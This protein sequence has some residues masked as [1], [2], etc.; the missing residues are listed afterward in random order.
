MDP[1]KYSYGVLLVSEDK[2]VYDIINF[3]ENLGWEENENE[4]AARLSFTAKNDNTSKGWLSSLAKP[5]CYVYL[6]ARYANGAASERMRGRIV[7]WNPSAKSREEILKI[8]AY[9]TLY[10]LQ[11]SKD[12]VYFSSGA[13]TRKIIT[14]ILSKWNIGL[15]AYTGPNVKHGTIKEEKKKLG[16]MLT[17]ILKEAKKKGGPEAIIRAVKGKVQVVK[18]CTNTKMY[19]FYE[20]ENLT[21]VSHKISTAGMITRVKVLGEENDDGKRPVEA[22]VNGKT[23]YGIRQDILIRGT[24]E[25]IQEAKKTARETLKEDGVPTE[26][27]KVVTADIP[28]LRKGD[29]IYLKMST[30]SGYYQILS[31]VHDCDQMEMTMELKKTKLPS[32]GSS[33]SSSK[34][35]EE[36]EYSVGD[37]VNFHGGT[38]YV[39]SDSSQGYSGIAA[40]KAKIT[41]TNPGSAHPWHLETLNWAQ[42]HVFGW[43]DEGTFD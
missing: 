29:A 5:G 31:I 6:Y 11:E 10:D 35:E 2:Q 34:K 43:V 28:A 38:H 1:L 3:I 19:Y 37:V 27:I 26:E 42:T 7:E 20:T 33:N 18:V 22:T 40:G 23:K 16:S 39:A 9:D 17:E 13:S 21:S 15:S 41:Y 36:K 30:G 14:S 4:L 25:S 8:K 12:N 32:S 24:D